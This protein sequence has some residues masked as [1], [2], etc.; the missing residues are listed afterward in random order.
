MPLHLAV[1][2]WATLLGVAQASPP[3]V[4]RVPL[5]VQEDVAF[6]QVERVGSFPGDT[7]IEFKITW[8]KTTWDLEEYPPSFS[9][10]SQHIL[11][12]KYTDTVYFSQHFSVHEFS[13]NVSTKNEIGFGRAGEFFHQYEWLEICPRQQQLVFHRGDDARDAKN[14]RCAG[15]EG[16]ALKQYNDCGSPGECTLN[17]QNTIKLRYFHSKK[18]TRVFSDTEVHV[19]DAGAYA[20]YNG[21]SITIYK[22]FQPKHT[23][24]FEAFFIIEMHLVFFLHFVSDREKDLKIIW[25]MVPILYGSLFSVLSGFFIYIHSGIE[26]KLFHRSEI[27]RS[28]AAS[29]AFSLG[30][31]IAT[32]VSAALLQILILFSAPKKQ[33][34][35]TRVAVQLLYEMCLII[36]LSQILMGGSKTNLLNLFLMFILTLVV[37]ASRVRDAIHARD[38][39]TSKTNSNPIVQITKNPLITFSFFASLCIVTSWTVLIITSV[40]SP[41]INAIFLLEPAGVTG[42]ITTFLVYTALAWSFFKDDYKSTRTNTNNGVKVTGVRLTLQGWPLNDRLTGA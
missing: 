5:R 8:G 1:A 2:L 9:N 4:T 35:N 36:P 28:N 41:T 13:H 6:A 20:V 12:D 7:T 3:K 32:C 38:A 30:L 14:H 16:T 33:D 27:F 37:W 22:E 34:K 25:T 10:T 31:L 26:E 24:S 29:N 19:D 18:V 21:Q 11:G 40:W 39:L 23:H 42:T 17:N 15:S